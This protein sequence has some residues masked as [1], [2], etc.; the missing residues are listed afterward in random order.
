MR[1]AQVY[2][3]VYIER[4]WSPLPHTHFWSPFPVSALPPRHSH[5]ISLLPPAAGR[6]RGGEGE[7]ERERE[8]EGARARERDRE[9]ERERQTDTERQRDREERDVGCLALIRLGWQGERGWAGE[10]GATSKQSWRRS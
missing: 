3:Y 2:I 4:G 7:G 5:T 9:R 8:A 6:E 10:D 1:V